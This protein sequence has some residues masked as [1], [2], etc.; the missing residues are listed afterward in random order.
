MAV[1]DPIGQY[2]SKLGVY[3]AN[4]KQ[5]WVAKADTDDSDTGVKQGD[6]L[7]EVLDKIFSG[8]NH[9]PQGHFILN[10]FYKDRSAVSSIGGF[11]V[12]VTNERPSSTAFYS[13]RVFYACNSKVYFSQLLTGKHKAGLCYQ[14]ADPTSE[15]ISDLIAT[16]GGVIPIPEANKIVRLLAA[17]DGVLVFAINGVWFVTGTNAGFSALDISVNKI[18]PI[19]CRNPMSIVETDQAVLWWSDTGIMA[20]SP[21]SGMYGPI[22]GAFQKQNI[23]Q[24]TIQTFYDSIP[25][26]SKRLVKGVFDPTANVVLWL[27]N[28]GAR[29]T[30]DYDSV[31]L[32][33]TSLNAFYP[34]KFS[35]SGTK[36]AIKGLFS[37]ETINQISSGDDV[38]A[39]GVQVQANAEDVEVNSFSLDI[40]PSTIKFS[41]HYLTDA[42]LSSVS[43]ASFT[44]WNSVDSVGLSYESYVETGY[45]LMN[46]AM[47]NKS[48]THLF[49][50]L[51]RTETS[52][53]YDE[54][55]QPFLNDPSSCFMTVK[56]DW[57]NSNKSGKWT[58]P[59]Q[60]YR[61]GRFL[62]MEEFNYETGF[63]IVVTKNKVRGNGKSIQFRFGT[64][65]P[66]R[67]FD[68][69]GWSVALTGNTVA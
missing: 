38:T 6:F 69:H 68:L 56:F 15:D 24:D 53:N 13:G 40:R 20:A 58:T 14:E 30:Y 31:L 33:D 3:P 61:S 35:T 59:V 57:A 12:E 37:S 36:P 26:S 10:E 66:G 39:G 46:D 49:T 50:Y 67:N 19:G 48:I 41:T 1:I 27:Y 43:S 47:R 2:Y 25:E 28:S 65:E 9:A 44:D 23:S 21:Q 4:N 22:P 60:V 55:D 52:W 54:D 63:P 32:F 64:S 11:D 29:A 42:R 8:N 45:E 16:D 5:W 34:W 17:A 18:S 62:P 51:R 7:P